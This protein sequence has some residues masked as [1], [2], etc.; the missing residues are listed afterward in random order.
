MQPPHGGAAGGACST[1]P[2]A[3]ISEGRRARSGTHIQKRDRSVRSHP[4][5]DVYVLW[6]S[7]LR[8]RRAARPIGQ[9][10][11]PRQRQPAG[12]F[13]VETSPAWAG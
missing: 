3:G 10:E 1:L 5:G 12:H 4:G 6:A 8:V 9:C 7:N 11:Q 13:L 2:I